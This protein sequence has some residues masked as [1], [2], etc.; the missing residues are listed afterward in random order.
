MI[1]SARMINYLSFPKIALA[2]YRE[3]R[4]INLDINHAI[5]DYLFLLTQ[6]STS[7]STS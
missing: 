2:I 7:C 4:F 3:S 1:G 5:Q 6:A